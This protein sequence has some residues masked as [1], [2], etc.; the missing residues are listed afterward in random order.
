MS[1][2]VTSNLTNEEIKVSL[3]KKDPVSDIGEKLAATG[4]ESKAQKLADLIENIERKI[5][6]IYRGLRNNK[7]IRF[8]GKKDRIN[9]I[10]PILLALNEVD[11]CNL[12]N[13]ITNNI[14]LDGENSS[15]PVKTINKLQNKSKKLIKLIDTLLLSSDELVNNNITL[16]DI[17][18]ILNVIEGIKAN[19]GD[20]IN[21]N[22]DNINLLR[23]NPQSYIKSNNKLQQAFLGV[24]DAIQEISS[25][26]DDPDLLAVVPQLVQGNNFINDFLTKLDRTVTLESIPNQEARKIFKKLRDLR[27]ILSLIVGINSLRDALGAV[28]SISGLN[29]DRQIQKVQKSLSISK[30]IP[31]IQNIIKTVNNINQIGQKL[32]KYV[33]L[34]QTYIKLTSSIIKVFRAIIKLLKKLPIPAKFMLVGKI[35]KF[36]EMLNK[37]EDKINSALR[38]LDALNTIIQLI[39]SFIQNLLVKLQNINKQLQILQNNLEICDNTGNLSDIGNGSGDYSD[40]VDGNNPNKNSPLIEE[41]KKARS[42]ITSTIEDLNLFINKYNQARALNLNTVGGYI[43]QIQEEELVDEGI[44]YK[45]RR[46]IALDNNGILVAQTD[47]TFATDTNIILEEL[48]LKLQNL[49]YVQSIASSSTGYPDLDALIEDITIE[50]DFVEEDDEELDNEY[51]EIQ[52]ELNTVIDSIKGAPKLRRRIKQKVDKEIEKT[53]QEIKEGTP[54]DFNSPS[55]AN[56]LNSTLKEINTGTASSSN[57]S[58]ILSDEERSRLE[59]ELKKYKTLLESATKSR[60]SNNPVSLSIIANYKVKIKEIESKLDKDKKARGL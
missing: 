58:D 53:N 22:K 17:V 11:F 56:A 7:G 30:L 6:E 33:K 40:L 44:K 60:S 29:I 35:M 43:L 57:N 42:K 12:I 31:I 34:I 41:I 8:P 15:G 26:V 51:V 3:E 10:M 32:L 25:I 1:T 37:F 19:V 48:K 50:D 36:S 4:L 28:Q 5:D 55:A 13:Y 2:S 46:G 47:L 52:D 14:P 27:T 16:G 24:R 45:R 20:R 54:P 21:V 39:L 23:A 38:I 59:K 9:G 49:G 18:T